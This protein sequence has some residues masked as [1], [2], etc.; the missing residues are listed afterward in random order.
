MKFRVISIPPFK[1]ASSGVDPHND[2]SENGVLGKFDAYF[3]KLRPRPSDNFTP[4]DFLYFDAEQ[5]GLVWIYAL[6]DYMD[7]EEY[8]VLD[9]DG[10][11]YVTYHYK[12]GDY[13]ENERLYKEAM[14]W[15]EESDTFALDI[16]TNHYAMGHIITPPE[17]IRATGS[18]QMESFIPI[19]L[20]K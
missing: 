17:I 8:E 5:G 12:D 2:F 19:K 11:F 9:F 15:I 13:E 14:T 3:S 20:K 18:A 4:R 10:G 16:R 6:T 7:A 1:A